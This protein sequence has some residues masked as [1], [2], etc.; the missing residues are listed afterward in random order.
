MARK[1]NFFT[2]E[3]KRFLKENYLLFSDAKL[4][5]IFDR[6]EDNIRKARQ[7]FGLKRRGAELKKFLANVPVVVWFPRDAFKDY[8][9]DLKQFKIKGNK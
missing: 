4:A 3:E 8:E 9:V 5:E 7:L 2:E 6:T 1:Y